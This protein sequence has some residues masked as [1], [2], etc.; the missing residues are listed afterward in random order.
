MLYGERLAAESNFMRHA[1]L[2]AAL[3]FN[4]IRGSLLRIL[5]GAFAPPL[6]SVYGF[7][8]TDGATLVDDHV[9]EP[10][11]NMV[12]AHRATIG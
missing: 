10:F 9:G 3:S 1:S 6:Q 11:H 2:N 8:T 4:K 12:P 5:C 7:G